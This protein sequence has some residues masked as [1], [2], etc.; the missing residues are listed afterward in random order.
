MKDHRSP[1]RW[2]AVPSL[3]LLVGLPPGVRPLAAQEGAVVGTVRDATTGAGLS[4]VQV[5][6]RGPGAAVVAGTLTSEAGTY[7]IAGVP[8]GSYTAV[9]SIPGWE[10]RSEPVTVSAGQSTTLDVSLAERAYNLNP[11][12][13]TTSKTQEKVLDAPAAIEVVNTRDIFERPATTIVDHVKEQAGVDVITT[14]LQSNY[15]VVRG[16]N[17]IFSGATLTLTDNRIARVPSL[18]ANISHLNPTSSLDLERVEVVLGPG[19]ALYGPNAANGVIHSITKSP[20]DHPGVALSFGN[21]VR[22]QATQSEEVD[23]DGDGSPDTTVVASSSEEYVGHGEGRIAVRSPNGKVGFKLSGQYFN[24]HDYNFIDEEEVRQQFEARGCQAAAYDPTADPCTAFTQGLNPADPD[25]AELLRTS[26]DNVA[27]GR[28]NNLERWTLDGRLDFRPA[29]DVNV[30]LSGGRTQALSSVDLT[31]LGAGQVVDWG[32]TYGQGRVQVRDF[33]GQVFFNKSDNEDTYL[34]RSGR[35]LVDRSELFVAQLQHTSRIGNREKLVYGVDVLRT[36]PKSA[37]T[38]NGRHE[39]DDDITEVGGYVQ[40][41]TTLSEMWSLVLAARLDDH[42]RLDDIIFSP[43]AALV[44]KPTQEHSLRATYNRSY[45]TPTTL[46]LFLDISGASVPL[47]GPFRYDVRAQ[48]TTEN[49]F[50]FGRTAG[51]PDH[52]SPFNCFPTFAPG[53]ARAFLPTTTPQLW[54]EARAAVQALAAADPARFGAA[55][56]VLTALPPPSD[57]DVSIVA[58]TL[59]IDDREFSPTPGGLAGVTDLP[60]IQETITQTFEVGYKGLIANRVLLA[61]NAYYSRI[62]NFVS[63]LRVSTPNVFLN[64]Q[65]VAAYLAG[66]GVPPENAAAIGALVG[67]LPLGVVTP[68]TV[69]GTTDATLILTYRNLGDL[70]LFGGDLSATFLLTDEWELNVTASF[71][72]DDQFTT[73]EGTAGEEV[74]PL[75]APTAKGSASLGYRNAEVGFNAA[76]RARFVNGFPVNSGVYIGDQ[77]GYE[78]FDLNLGY[79][80]PGTPLTAQL[81]VQN[82]FDTDY[83]TFVGSPS[84]GRFTLL[85]LRY[86][87]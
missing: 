37:G 21:G 77:E 52:Q 50:T 49:G 33:F 19:S 51:V 44:F 46:N 68:T 81:D 45:S 23:L 30:I 76:A 7:R 71:V 59:N 55:A 22:Q 72:S 48:G 82:V 9:F 67:G 6:L 61:A 2:L 75:N 79:R 13:V 78:V 15:T 24:S 18:R 32:Y 17:N 57:Q 66:F 64:G 86:D 47:F 14:G 42:S 70:D 85:R 34:L 40:S 74:V 26:V 58:L 65:E 41:E 53:C 39:S 1:F 43:R 25:D 80:I 60:A 31:G 73:G 8:A 11:I 16:F 62:E 83:T 28:D 69:G 4:T 27:R 12:T 35:P 56:A 5:E 54:A 38:I 63:A 20:I 29:S 84:L 3:L 36:V 10:V 87:M